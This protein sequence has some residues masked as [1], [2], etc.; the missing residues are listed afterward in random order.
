MPFGLSIGTLERDRMT[1]WLS[2]ANALLLIRLRLRSTIDFSLHTARATFSDSARHVFPMPWK[3]SLQGDSVRFAFSLRP[4]GDA[5]HLAP[6]CPTL[7]RPTCFDACAGTPGVEKQVDGRRLHSF[8]VA[9]L[10]SFVAHYHVHSLPARAS[11]FCV[12]L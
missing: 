9:S 6:N 10:C 4:G 2:F 3:D 7:R 8:L 12:Q 1:K 11:W 5:E